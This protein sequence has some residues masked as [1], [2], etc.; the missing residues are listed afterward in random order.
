MLHT[1]LLKLRFLAP[2]A[3]LT[4]AVPLGAAQDDAA[5]KAPIERFHHVDQ[6]LYRGA[7][8]DRKG[9]EFLHGMGVRTVINLRQ[10]AD[11]VKLDEQRIVE[12]LGM[13]YVNIPV[14]DGNFFTRGR[15]IPDDA[16]RE[17]F[18]TLDTAGP[19]G[20]FVHCHRGADRTGA[21]VGFY[22]IARQGWDGARAYAE[23]KEIGMRSWY[24]GLKR[25]VESFAQHAG[26]Y[27]AV[28]ATK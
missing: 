13:R 8:P 10:K 22:R 6:R 21:I 4:V 3:L 9:F 25:Q 15:T 23:A 20:V 12:G 7:Q 16:I 2:V 19:G 1:R 27:A 18:Q 17:F 14:E 5:P 24:R 11:A 26:A 28:T